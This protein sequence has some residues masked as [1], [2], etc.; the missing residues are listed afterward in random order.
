MFSRTIRMKKMLWRGQVE[1][2]QLHLL[3]E[4][5]AFADR[6]VEPFPAFEEAHPP[7]RYN[8]ISKTALLH[9]RILSE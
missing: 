6:D 8:F 1:A 2:E 5:E 9:N 3:P 7:E 4:L